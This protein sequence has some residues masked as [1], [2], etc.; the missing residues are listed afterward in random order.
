MSPKKE[1]ALYDELAK[2][3]RG[4]SPDRL[5]LVLGKTES[6]RMRVTPAEK[7][8]MKRTASR[9]G[10][11]LTEYLTRLHALAEEITERKKSR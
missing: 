7:D 9:Y 11:T 10:L 5:A 4:M 8:A 2:A 6:V 3:V 1:K